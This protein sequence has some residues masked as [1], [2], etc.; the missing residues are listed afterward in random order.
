MSKKK[1]VTRKKT[2]KAGNMAKEMHPDMEHIMKYF[3]K[4]TKKKCKVVF[5]NYINGEDSMTLLLGNETVVHVYIN[6]YPDEEDVENLLEYAK[7]E[8]K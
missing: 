7:D 2:I 5:C 3:E 6:E 1:K 4:E 8:V